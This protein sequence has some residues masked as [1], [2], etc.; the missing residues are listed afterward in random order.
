MK[1]K[2]TLALGLAG[3]IAF[4]PMAS[5]AADDIIL[6]NENKEVIAEK[7]ESL[8]YMEYAGE[9][10]DI[11]KDEEKDSLSILVEGMDKNRQEK[12]VFHIGEDMTLVDEKTKDLIERDD[13][14]EGREVSVFY[15]ENTPMTMSIPA[16]I[17]PDALLVRDSNQVGSVKVAN[18]NSQ[19]VD[20]DNELKL[21]VS[22]ET[23]I[24][25]ND[26]EKASKDKLADKD[27]MVFY[28][29]TTRSIPAQTSP[30][31]IIILDDMDLEEEVE[32]S[33][34]RMDKIIING[35]SLDLDNE[36]YKSAD[37]HHM[38][39]LRQ[40]GEALGYEVSWNNEERSAEL[41]KGAQWTKVTIGSKDYNFAKMLVR[42][43]KAPEI[44]DSRTYVPVEFLEEVLRVDLDVNNGVLEV[45][46]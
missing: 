14:K 40:V 16:Q 2:R 39:G 7:L 38:I 32:E 35:E 17:S 10:T 24:V 9:I 44:K 45:K 21:N 28:T 19:L 4:T 31:K 34:T 46:E 11:V 29:A 41:M 1:G 8:K 27:L 23:D 25:D 30:E 12:I 37:G 18:F 13:L 42:L 43:D 6:T 3:L 33:L 20:P 15:K 22:D 26:G 36:I 5:S